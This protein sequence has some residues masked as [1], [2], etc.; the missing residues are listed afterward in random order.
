M[1]VFYTHDTRIF[2]PMKWFV[3]LFACYILLLSGIPC[4]AADE[5]CASE[6]NNTTAANGQK[7]KS[8]HQPTSPCSPFFTCNNCHGV[9][10]PDIKI[11][12]TGHLL[13]RPRLSF[14]YTEQR[15]ADYPST[16][17]QPPQAE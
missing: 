14:Q 16:I 5:C 8:D 9:V 10:L 12:F 4:N 13:P 1:T 6:I 15:L 2:A 3:Y 7:D 17:W 11:E